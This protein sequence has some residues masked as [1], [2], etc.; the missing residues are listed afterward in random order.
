M[1]KWAHVS[2]QAA[3][4]ADKQASVVISLITPEKKKEGRYR[5]RKKKS[6]V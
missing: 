4:A 6:F 2:E 5:N 1:N 3:K